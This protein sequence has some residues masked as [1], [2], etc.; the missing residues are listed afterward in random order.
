MKGLLRRIE[1]ADGPQG[2]HAKGHPFPVEMAIE[3]YRH[4]EKGDQFRVFSVN[5]FPSRTSRVQ[6]VE[7]WGNGWRFRTKNTTYELFVD[8]EEKP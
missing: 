6:S 2:P 1:T 4:P 8:E 3:F 7:E 5:G